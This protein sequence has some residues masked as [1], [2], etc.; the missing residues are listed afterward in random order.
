MKRPT[1]VVAF[2][3]IARDVTI[4]LED[5]RMPVSFPA[6]RLVVKHYGEDGIL[7]AELFAPD[8]S[9]VGFLPASDVPA[10]II[11]VSPLEGISW[12]V[13]VVPT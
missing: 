12:Q 1:V 6:D 13:T 4:D 9:E 10:V 8:E 3:P 11:Q 7:F 2:D 5:G